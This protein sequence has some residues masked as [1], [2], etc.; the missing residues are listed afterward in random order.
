MSDR[1]SVSM[2]D[3]V[4]D[5]RLLRADKMNALDTAMFEALV[6]TAAR[7]RTENGLRAVVLSGE[8]KA[9]CAG[10]DMS[11]FA[12]MKDRGG[13]GIAG[14]EKRDL[15][16]RTHGIANHSQQAVWG[17]RQLPV[18]VIAAVH[19]VAFGGGFQLALGADM[20]FLAPD[21]RM[22]IMEIKWGLVPDMAGT[23]ILASLV[24]DDILRELTFTGRIFSAQEA[25]SYG[26]ATRIC[27]DPRQAAL[28]V[29]RDI[30]SKSPDA[31]RAAKRLLNNLIVDPASALL[32]ESVEQMK[33]MGSHNQ[34][35]AVLA[36]IEKRAP[37]FTD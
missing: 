31:V 2:S 26:L 25:L 20:R 27:E 36:N 17:W 15:A 35:E 16:T 6:D 29:A 12:D 8:G 5:V 18:P 33:L 9:F 13:N 21:A 34:T 28:E 14:G 37:S 1:I 32:A 4:A 7:L 19:G 30:A 23:P 10:L 3:G 11:R 24:R 22:S